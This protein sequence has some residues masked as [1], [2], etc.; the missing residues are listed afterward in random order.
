[1]TR[2]LPSELAGGGG[3]LGCPEDAEG[4]TSPERGEWRGW[5]GGGRREQEGRDTEALGLGL[6]LGLGLNAPVEHGA[7]TGD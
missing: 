6:G 2:V 7:G 5:G 3:R 4:M 1:M